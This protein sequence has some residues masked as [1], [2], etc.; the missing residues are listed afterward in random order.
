MAGP[1]EDSI[2]TMAAVAVSKKSKRGMVPLPPGQLTMT[3]LDFWERILTSQA[4]VF[5]VKK[6]NTSLFPS[7]TPS[8]TKRIQSSSL[9]L[10]LTATAVSWRILRSGQA[11][12]SMQDWTLYVAASLTTHVQCS[13]S[14][15]TWGALFLD[16]IWSLC[17][18]SPTALVN[19]HGSAVMRRS[20]DARLQLS[21]KTCCSVSY[22]CEA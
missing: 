4:L 21:V 2:S 3:I 19:G 10:Y 16:K 20:Q 22:L 11:A 12:R 18:L 14:P 7:H 5:C 17:L 15:R 1:E 13:L 6:G 8:N 9:T